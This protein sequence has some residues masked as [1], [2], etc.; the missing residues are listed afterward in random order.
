LSGLSLGCFVCFLSSTHLSR[1]TF[2]TL[3]DDGTIKRVPHPDQKVIAGAMPPIVS[4]EMFERAQRK[5]AINRETKSQRPRDPEQ[6]LLIGHVYCAI[7]GNRM[8]PICEKML[9]VYRCNKHMSIYDSNPHCEPHILRIKTSITDPIVWQDCCH[10]FERLDLIQARIEEEINHSI[11][12]LLED[13]TGREQIAVLKAAIE[14]AKQERDKQQ[15]EYLRSLIAQDIQTKTEQLQR[16]EEECKAASSIAALTATYQQRVLEFVEFVNVMRGRYQEATFQEKRNA[17]DVLGVKVFVHPS[18]QEIPVIQV[19]SEEEWLTI[20]K[21]R[22][23]KLATYPVIQRAIQSGLLPTHSRQVSRTVI[24]RDELNRFLRE[25]PIKSRSLAE[26][27]LQRIEIIYSPLFVGTG[28]QASKA[29]Q[30]VV[31]VVHNAGLA[32]LVARLKPVIVI[33]G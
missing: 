4:P 12:N 7:C 28:V 30:Q 21:L 15:N 31:N 27:V 8:K 29:A 3:Q 25:S 16:F 20:R 13:T 22:T 17:L 9:P 2:A 11:S 26:D 10:L 18:K 14:H 6:Y 32:K 5:L 19:E 24:H 33:K 23:I 1:S